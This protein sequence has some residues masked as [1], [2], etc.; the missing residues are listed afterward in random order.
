MRG[1]E[2][3]GEIASI[4]KQSVCDRKGA[5]RLTSRWLV[6]MLITGKFPTRNIHS[7]T[8]TLKFQYNS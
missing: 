8:D 7:K 6:I 2:G 4:G 1:R 3:T 5:E